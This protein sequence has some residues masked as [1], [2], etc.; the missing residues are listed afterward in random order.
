MQLSG[1]EMFWCA[2]CCGFVRRICCSQK[3]R[4]H[5]GCRRCVP[6]TKSWQGEYQPHNTN[7]W[8]TVIT[9]IPHTSY[10][11]GLSWTRELHCWII[12]YKYF[13]YLLL[14]LY[15]MC[16]G[17]AV[18]TCRPVRPNQPCWQHLGTAWFEPSTGQVGK[19]TWWGTNI[20]NG[21][22]KN[23][24]LFFSW[25]SIAI[26]CMIL[27]VFQLSWHFWILQP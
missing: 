22:S 16:K 17:E 27:Y 15:N 21:S 2:S 23:G 3:G 1:V 9:P 25:W 4:I 5:L 20:G 8:Y 11:H 6:Q 10:T 12:L 7:I 13:F 14:G 26:H 18:V 19:W 24:S